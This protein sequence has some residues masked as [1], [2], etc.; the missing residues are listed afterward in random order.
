MD[1]TEQKALTVDRDAQIQVVVQNPDWEDDSIDLGR[2]FLNMKEKRRIY[3]WVMVLCLVLGLCLPLLIYQFTKDPLT[4]SSVVSLD[5][6][7]PAGRNTELRVPVSNLTAP[8]GTPLDLNQVTS[9]YVLQ[10]A[11][12]G[13]ELSQPVT[14]KNLR[15]NI[16]IVRILTE[17]SR[18]QQEVASKMVG[19]K[20]TNA[21][22]QVKSLEL[23]YE[24]K[25]VVSLTNGFGEEDSRIRYY[26]KDEE[27]RLVLDRILSAYNGYLVKT[28]SQLVLPDD[29]IS[30]IDI[31]SLDFLDSLDLMRTAAENLYNYCD[32]Q[33]EEIKT[34]RSWQTGK[35]LTDWMET[36]ETVRESSVDYLYSYVYNASLVKDYAMVI[37]D[38]Q[39]K[40]RN[41]ETQLDIVKN[42]IATNQTIL[43]NYKNDEIFVTMQESDS[44]RS[45]QTTTDYYNNLI[46]Q[47]AEN[48][49]QL[50]VLEER[51]ADLKDKIESIDEKNATTAE[52]LAE[53]EQVDK[54]LGEVV[55]SIYTIYQGINDHMKEIV[56]SPVS[57]TYVDSSAAQGKTANFLVA[58]A[59][60]MA[61]GAAAGLVIACGLW[62]LSALAPEFLGGSSA[63]QKEKTRREAAK[64]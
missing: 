61:I 35:S 50:A 37:T 54:E 9:S 32:R 44:T 57:M 39:Y 2:V 20:N 12:S 59:K 11:M 16:R 33:R 64:A 34:Y 26:L 52:N 30:V 8:D 24:K 23:E 17:E 58:S 46:L 5:Y 18:Q 56:E 45:T 13:I 19:D 6:T 28:Y 41:A 48:Y 10:N 40:L 55:A 3:A 51:I 62:F 7:V 21:Y 22:T 38:Y 29:E 36:L 43:D 14:L 25:F 53:E 27:L 49:K 63:E 47:Q 4:V 60:N 15:D 42:N 31:K 1:N